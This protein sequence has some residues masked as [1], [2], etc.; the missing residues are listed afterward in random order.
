MESL[1][2]KLMG[3]FEKNTHL[4]DKVPL[5]EN[6]QDIIKALWSRRGVSL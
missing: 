4:V 5:T 1:Y 2:L 6:A 3:L